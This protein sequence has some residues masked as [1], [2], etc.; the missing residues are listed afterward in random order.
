[1]AYRLKEKRLEPDHVKKHLQFEEMELDEFHCF[2]TE[3]GMKKV[4]KILRQTLQDT[5][6]IWVVEC[7]LQNMKKHVQGFDYRIPR[8]EEG[9]PV[10]VVWITENKSSRC[11]WRRCRWGWCRRRRCRWSWCRRR[12]ADGV[13]ADGVGA[14]GIGAD[15]VGADGVGA[16]CVGAEGI[17]VDCVGVE[18]VGAEGVGADFVRA[19]CAGADGVRPDRVD[20]DGVDTEGVGAEGVSADGVGADVWPVLK[21]WVQTSWG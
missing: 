10:G 20:A 2:E 18:S 1:M 11:R 17:M 3:V 5:G 9:R 8:N 7:F 19:D 14:D 21:E 6:E 15:G 16:D 4:K 12:S 13:G